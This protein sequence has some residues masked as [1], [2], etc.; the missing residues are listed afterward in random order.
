M[1]YLSV[2]KIVRTNRF[3]KDMKRIG[4]SAADLARLES[5]LVSNPTA[6]DVIPGLGGIR[7]VRFGFGGRGKRGGGRAIYLLVVSDDLIALLRAYAKAEQPDLTPEEK[8][9]LAALV[10]EILE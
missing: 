2:M 1:A 4:A 6:G 10:K 9:G 3:L 5:A 8:R 7:K